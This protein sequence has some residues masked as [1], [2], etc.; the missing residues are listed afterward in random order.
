[1]A[2]S[3]LEVKVYN[4]SKNK[5]NKVKEPVDPRRGSPINS[6]DLFKTLERRQVHYISC[7]ASR[8]NP[9]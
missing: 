6:E 7:S 1:M 4:F 5:M 8:F 3:H 2:A 9:L